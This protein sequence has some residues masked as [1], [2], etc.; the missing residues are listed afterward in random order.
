MGGSILPVTV[1]NNKLYFL[2]GKERDIDENPGWSDFGG[3]TDA[4]ESFI[5][6]ASREGSEELTG[7]LGDATEIKKLM[8]K[9]GTHNIDYKSNGHT[10]YRC[11]IVPMSFPEGIH[12]LPFYYNNN[13]RFLQKRLDPQI[14]TDSKIF[15]K[16]QIRWFSFDDMK[17]DHKKFRS[18]YQNIVSL[19]LNDKNAIETFARSS[20]MHS[21]KKTRVHNRRM[22]KMN[23]TKR[24]I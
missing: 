7:F 18:F 11:H 3:G 20:L 2:F 12:L 22:Q 6:T 13:Q 16:A 15:E 5:Q 9:Y 23:K 17:K 21:R 10:T 8:S 4:G 24:R 1:H 14:I 19:I